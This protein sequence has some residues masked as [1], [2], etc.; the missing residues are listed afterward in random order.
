LENLTLKEVILVITKKK[1]SHIFPIMLAII[2][3][4]VLIS[5]CSSGSAVKSQTGSSTSQPVS[6]SSQQVVSTSSQPTATQQQAQQGSGDRKN[7][8][9]GNMKTVI[10]RVAAILNVSEANLTSAVE[11]AMSAN[12]PAGGNGGP[13][14]N[15]TRPS[16]GP[17]ENGTP[18][19]GQPPQGGQG[20]QSPS[21]GQQPGGSDMME[22]VYSSVASTLGLTSDTVKAA[23]EQAYSELGQSK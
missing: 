12:R 5:G 22:K 18:P 2:I 14:D 6:S 10:T 13:S 23:F 9:A 3:I 11:A 19:S 15:G 8:G 7:G 20:G 4:S 17:S 16:G 21:G 1:L